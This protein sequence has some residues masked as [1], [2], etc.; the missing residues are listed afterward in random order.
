ML[1]EIR[2]R[3]YRMR[4]QIARVLMR[5]ARGRNLAVV[6]SS[7]VWR[8]QLSCIVVRAAWVASVIWIRWL[9]F[10]RIVTMVRLALGHHHAR[11]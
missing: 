3:A 9:D 5:V 6:A 4:L 10:K 2:Y 1:W 8:R 11:S 7:H